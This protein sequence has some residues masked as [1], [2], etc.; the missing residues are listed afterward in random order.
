MAL[1]IP[2][3]K[4]GDQL[5]ADE[6]NELVEEANKIDHKVEKE[7]GKGLSTNDYTTEDK[8]KLS[9]LENYDDT[10]LNN[11][12]SAVEDKLETVTGTVISFAESEVG[13]LKYCGK[14]YPVF[15]LSAEL[16][17]VPTTAGESVDIVISDNPLGNELYLNVTCL[18][19]ATTGGFAPSAHEVSSVHVDDEMNTI[20]SI[21]C[22][23]TVTNLKKVILT[24]RYVKGILSFDTFTLSVPTSELGIT[25]ADDVTVTFPS[26]KYD[27]KFA[28]SWTTDD[29][30][31]CV[32]SYLC[33]YINKKYIDDVYNFHDGMTPTTGFTP[34]R[35]LCGTDGCGNDV[36]FRVDSGWVSFNANGSDGIHSDSYPYPY[37]RWSEMITFL[38][39]F[40]TAMN[41]GGGDQT[42][43]LESIEMCGKR[44]DEET[45]YFPFLLLVPGGTTGYEQVAET[46]DYIYHYHDKNNLNY[47]V[48]SLTKECFVQ[49]HGLL[50]RKIYDGM[51]LD[52]LRAYID[53][54]A[55]R[56]DHPYTYMGGHVIADAN[57]QIKWTAA[58]KPFLDY[59]HDTYGKGGN[60]SIWFAGPAEVYEYLFT[61]F[62]SVISKKIDGDNLE[63]KVKIARLPL[64]YQREISLLVKKTARITSNVSTLTVNE[65]VSRLSHGLK[66]GNLL[67]NLN[68]NP[69]LVDLAEKYTSKYEESSRETNK[70]DA[71]YFAN[72]LNDDLKAPF[73][74]RIN[75]GD[76]APVL[77]SISINSGAET[78]HDQE[79]SVLLDVTGSIS[80]YKIS[81][82]SDLSTV[83]WVEGTFKTI[84][85]NLSSDFG[86]KTIYAQAKNSFG[87][88]GIKS[89]SITLAE[90]PSVTYTV[91][92]LSN[93][94]ALGSV[95]P[96][97]QEV[98]P[99]GSVTVTAT[100]TT[101]NIIDSWEGVD[102]GTGVG[103]ASGT[104]QVLNVLSDKSVTCN[105]K[106]A[107][108]PSSMK[109]IVYP[110]ISPGVATL[111]SGEK[112]SGIRG[113][114]AAEYPRPEIFDT[115]GNM[116]G[117]Q[118]ANK[119]MLPEGIIDSISSPLLNPVLS[120]DTG[121]YP[122]SFLRSLYGV[123]SKEVYPTS[124][125]LLRFELPAG[126]YKIRVM[127]STQ[128][129]LPPAQLTGITYDAN[130]IVVNIPSSYGA[131]NNNSEFVDINNVIVGADGILDI[132]MGSTTAWV[133]AGWNL[134]E[135][136][137]Q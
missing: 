62:Y 127:Y 2:T 88:S 46:L 76:T 123:Y 126:T 55:A 117:H 125:G 115:S 31:L 63:I 137:K 65:Q 42:K 25:S 78:T 101:G 132:Y 17:G 114:F 53:T 33:K 40:N 96:S 66:D 124:K 70:E 8:N 92:A 119:D 56:D 133:V 9:G 14:D 50:G 12:V 23:E 24:I 82:S 4:T 32:Y 131:T 37:V 85:F 99:G 86:L 87:E 130:G 67:I 48:D 49:R 64:F 121:V 5:T 68:Y 95:S 69:K 38:D 13:T 21:K 20:V 7:P 18:S 75:A 34:T 26:L 84:P 79:V 36:R 52:E 41:H 58:V 118:V 122:D 71:L 28:L 35:V 3:K 109:I 1:N 97:T 94:A 102:S 47:S 45:G 16:S 60:D 136:I 77:N 11:R 107:P 111:P 15:E 44:L 54:Q 113:S 104:G 72:L 39:F 10:A 83:A 100:A 89:S 43:P 29:A 134:M 112:I 129:V 73:L 74:A 106:Q 98:E 91:T 19:I 135:I 57:E 80:H 59:L 103:T 27:K 30:L 22:K 93:N 128:K 116:V 81:E 51:T 90:A 61:R 108:V 110:L 120:G 6:F 105:F